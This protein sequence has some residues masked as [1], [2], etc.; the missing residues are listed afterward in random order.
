MK[1]KQVNAF[2]ECV[3][4]YDPFLLHRIQAYKEICHLIAIFFV[5]KYLINV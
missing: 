3:L 2:L 4:R 1:E 5:H